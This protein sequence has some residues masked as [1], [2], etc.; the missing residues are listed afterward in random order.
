MNGL[1]AVT[2]GTLELK[3]L[4]NVIQNIHMH[5]DYIHIREKKRTALELSRLVEQCLHDG[6]PSYKLILN[7]RLDV[8]ICMGLNRVHLAGHSLEVER[9]KQRFPDL[10]IGRSVHA[11][12]EALEMQQQGADY[13]YYG[14][15][16]ETHSKPGIPGRGLLSLREIVLALHIPVV[17]IGGI[18]QGDRIRD[19]MHTGAS[20]VAVMSGIW[21]S[22]N[23]A[24]AAQVFQQ[25]WIRER[26]DTAN[27]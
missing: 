8:A 25:N 2:D 26:R 6:V 4:A 11:L 23:P 7:D 27:E 18:K 9:V 10:I 5:T 19:V 17:A 12:E 16:Y 22:E 3:S 20:G 15:I 13:L 14:H 1:H 21:Q 24:L